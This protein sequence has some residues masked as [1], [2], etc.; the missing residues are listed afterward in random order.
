MSKEQVKRPNMITCVDEL[1]R[2]K[3]GDKLRLHNTSFELQET[4]QF[5]S[6]DL[7]NCSD[8]Y[9]YPRFSII[10]S[11]GK[12]DDRSLIDYG[13]L[14]SCSGHYNAFNWIERVVGP[15]S[16]T[17]EQILAGK[18]QDCVYEIKGKSWEKWHMVTY[19][20]TKGSMKA[21]VIHPN[22]TVMEPISD[23]HS[24]GSIFTKT[25]KRVSLV[26]GK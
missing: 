13:V 10:K 6:L 14:P 26:D 11:N 15:T 12:K 7:S 20:D 1:I 25:N 18:L 3:R 24:R 4:V 9:W 16:Y 17:M 8:R 2:M 5:E 22:G 21:I 23:W 19:S